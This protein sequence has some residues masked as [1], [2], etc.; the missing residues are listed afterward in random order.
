MS[1]FD[2]VSVG[3]NTSFVLSYQLLELPFKNPESP[4]LI[5]RCGITLK[6]HIIMSYLEHV[7]LQVDHLHTSLDK[8]LAAFQAQEN[9]GCI[10]ECSKCCTSPNIEATILELLP[11]AFHLYKNNKAEI[12]YDSLLANLSP[13]CNLYKPIYTDLQ[14]GACSDYQHRALIC[15]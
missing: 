7:S 11:Y 14:K 6:F 9:Y 5:F 8:D 3:I 1:T 12:I 15:R 2:L 13:I 10:S 4:S